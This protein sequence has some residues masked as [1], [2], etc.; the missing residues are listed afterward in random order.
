MHTIVDANEAT[1]SATVTVDV[2]QIITETQ[3]SPNDTLE[4]DENEGE[5]EGDNDEN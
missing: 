5:S 1:A 3:Y 2:K 4:A